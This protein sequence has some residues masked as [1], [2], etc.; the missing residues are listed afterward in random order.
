[1]RKVRRMA[2]W[3]SNLL[4][5]YFEWEFLV[6]SII[7]CFSIYALSFSEGVVLIVFT[8][9]AAQLFFL[10]WMGTRVANRID[11]LSFEISKNWH[12][13]HPT[14]RKALQMILHW[15]Q[16]MKGFRSLFK[17]VSVETYKEVRNFTKNSFNNFLIFLQ[18]FWSIVFVLYVFKIN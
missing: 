12:L 1:M 7:L 2:K 16:T 13:M 18:A 5:W 10:C 4:S 8:F 17:D 15:T 6:Q 11:K 14:Q 3:C 9:C